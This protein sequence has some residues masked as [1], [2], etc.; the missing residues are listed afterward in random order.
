MRAGDDTLPQKFQ[1][2]MLIADTYEPAI[3]QTYME[4][5]SKGV[6]AED[7]AMFIGDVG[8]GECKL[9]ACERMA[10]V[11]ALVS[12]ETQRTSGRHTAP[13]TDRFTGKLVGE[14]G[15]LVGDSTGAMAILVS[16]PAPKGQMYLAV[17]TVYGVSLLVVCP[18][19][20]DATAKINSA[21]VRGLN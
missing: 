16:D 12:T 7:I 19:A 18:H 1:T 14:R 6:P 15:Q 13:E 11:R 17:F 2:A 5:L 20:K 4:M 21:G 10:L 9:V 8:G 3:R